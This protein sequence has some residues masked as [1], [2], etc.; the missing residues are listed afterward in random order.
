MTSLIYMILINALVP[1][2]GGFH[3]GASHRVF[4]R[5]VLK[6]D[7]INIHERRIEMNAIDSSDSSECENPLLDEEVCS[8]FTI[9]T[10]SSTA[11]T[12][13]KSSL[14]IDDLAVY[15]GLY[16]RKG[17][18]GAHA[19]EVE[20]SGCLGSCKFAPCVAIEHSEFHGTVG[21]EGMTDQEFQD[22]LFH[23]IITEEDIDRVWN[24]VENAIE[25]MSNEDED[26]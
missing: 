5:V 22:S 11:C 23:N 3:L 2:I 20:E 18:A 8:A 10:C 17:E 15:G 26:E 12:R 21:L 9:K 25:V 24:C 7:I 16:V 13:K 4:P 14:G 6:S 1:E 19:V